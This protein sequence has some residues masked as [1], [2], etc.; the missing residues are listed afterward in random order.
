MAVGGPPAVQKPRQHFLLVR[1]TATGR[2]PGMAVGGHPPYKKHLSK[3]GQD[4]L[5]TVEELGAFLRVAQEL[6]DVSLRGLGSDR[7]R[8][9]GDAVEFAQRFRDGDPAGPDLVVELQIRLL[10]ASRALRD[11]C[12]GLW[13]PYLQEPLR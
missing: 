8:I 9:V 13:Y 12:F 6:A 5:E 11:P 3:L 1:R 7:L 2:H 4:G 10:D